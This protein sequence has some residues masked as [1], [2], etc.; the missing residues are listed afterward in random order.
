MTPKRSFIGRKIITI[1]CVKDQYWFKK[2]STVSKINE[3]LL[4]YLPGSPHIYKSVDTIPDPE[5]VANYLTEFLNSLQPPGL[6][7]Y[8]L[9]L[10]VGTSVMLLRNLESPIL[11]NGIRLVVKKMMLHVTDATIPSRC[12][13]GE[14]VFIP[15]ISLIPLGAVIQLLLVLT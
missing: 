8:R 12:G 7:P 13:K 9:I 14:D 11:C 6:P 15:R 3:Q 1:S 2:N 10:K 5:E 4:Q